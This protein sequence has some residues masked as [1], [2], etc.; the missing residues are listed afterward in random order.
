MLPAM[1]LMLQAAPMF[2]LLVSSP[3]IH[4]SPSQH[5]CG[6]SLV[7]ALYVVCGA[8]GFFYAHRGERDLEALLAV[9]SK[10]SG[11]ENMVEG[12]PTKKLELKVK[13]GIVDQCCHRPC[14]LSHLQ[15]YCN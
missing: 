12:I 1:A 15:N 14:T 10:T 5:L 6:S 13:R 11:H 8:R 7:D 3:G 2:L 9:L 4:S